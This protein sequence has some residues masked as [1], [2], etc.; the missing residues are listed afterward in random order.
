MVVSAKCQ[1]SNATV[2]GQYARYREGFMLYS[3]RWLLREVLISIAKLLN[4]EKRNVLQLRY[5]FGALGAQG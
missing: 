1:V 5:G 4:C 2:F 3:S